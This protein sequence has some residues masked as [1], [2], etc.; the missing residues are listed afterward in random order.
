MSKEPR[1]TTYM[2][3][4]KVFTLFSPQFQ[5]FNPNGELIGYC[6]QKAFR[7]K[8]DI[9]VYADETMEQERVIIKARNI[10]DFSA[11]Y[12]VVDAESQQKLGAF[13]RK[14]FSSMFRDSWEI[15]DPSDRVVGKIL[16]D[17]AGMALVRRFLVNLI[18]QTFHASIND[19]E[20]ATYS[21]RFNLFV[22]KLDVDIEP[23]AKQM[24][25]DRLLL[26]GGLLLA[27]IE[28]RQK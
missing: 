10:I 8:E 15:L 9:R 25:D 19:R 24:V 28:G 3:R 22:Y 17:D 11:A 23:R 2:I 14:G 26:A 21:Q 20:V 12:D 16:E 1:E 13:R 7:L 4:R 18:P 6:K 27:A 5:I